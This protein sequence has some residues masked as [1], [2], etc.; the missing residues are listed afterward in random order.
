M[1]SIIF[2]EQNSD[3]EVN[4]ATAT[5]SARVLTLA[6][7]KLVFPLA[8]TNLQEFLSLV[9]IGKIETLMLLGMGKG[10]LVPTIKVCVRSDTAIDQAR[11]HILLMR[12]EIDWTVKGIISPTM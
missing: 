5:K 10:D 4:T 1:T 2:V 9:Q 8:T 12:E 7:Q 11:L 3:D 6:T